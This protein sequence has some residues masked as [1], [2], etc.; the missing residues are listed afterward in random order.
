MG[1]AVVPLLV[2][3]CSVHEF[4]RPEFNQFGVQLINVP[5][6]FAKAKRPRMNWKAR[7]FSNPRLFHST[8]MPEI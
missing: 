5:E 8:E 7:P 2:P 3:Y 1:L 6:D 4:N